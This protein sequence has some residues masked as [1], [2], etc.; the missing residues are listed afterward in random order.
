MNLGISL[1]ETTSW[2]VYK[3]SF[4]HSLVSTSRIIRPDLQVLSGFPIAAPKDN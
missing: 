1:K 2:M 3:G 4:P